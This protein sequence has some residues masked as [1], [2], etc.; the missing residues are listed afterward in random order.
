MFTFSTRS[1]EQLNTCNILLQTLFRVVILGYDCTI[2]EGYRS[3]KLQD[4]YFKE[5][6]S[7]VQYPNS[8]HNFNPSLAVDVA[9]HVHGK[10]VS[11]EPRQCY[12]FAGYVWRVAQELSIPIRAGCDWD[13]DIDINDQSF[14]DLVHFEL[15]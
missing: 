3:K 6:K 10:G 13:G 2:L 14:N 1:I 4:K 5:G 12:H 11:F 15:T 7:K 8:A 9:P